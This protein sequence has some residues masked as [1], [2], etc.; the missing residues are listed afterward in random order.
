MNA[1]T[2]DSAPDRKQAALAVL[3][4]VSALLTAY[5][6]LMEPVILR[7][8]ALAETRDAALLQEQKYMELIAR[9][10]EIEAQIAAL[11]SRDS[12]TAVLFA[13][14]TASIAGANLA[15]RMREIVEAAGGEVRSSRTRQPSEELDL[16]RIEVSMLAQLPFSALTEVLGEMELGKP[17]IFL[18]DVS[19]RSQQ[20]NRG[21][22]RA[23]TIDLQLNGRGYTDLKRQ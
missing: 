1:T 12:D 20:G 16:T 22:G 9:R 14:A 11:D 17:Y 8:R 5:V 21:G 18:D 15:S 3:L 7:Y 2:L 6:L 10:P 19:I 13:G 23:D 4:L